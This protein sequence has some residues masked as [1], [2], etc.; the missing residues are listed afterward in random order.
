MK[1]KIVFLMILGGLWSACTGKFQEINTNPNN[2]EVV[3]TTQVL[4][5]VQRAYCGMFGDVWY[6]YNES[7]SMAGQ[8]TKIRYIDEARYVY[9]EGTVNNMFN[10]PYV[11]FLKNLN[12]II[13]YE[14]VDNGN[15]NMVA[16]ARIFKAYIFQVMTDHLG[17]IPYFNAFKVLDK[18]Y[19]PEYDPQKDI[20]ADLIR[21]VQAAVAMI[22]VN[23]PVPMRFGNADFFF[24]GDMNRWKK[25]GNS[26][27]L[28]MAIRLSYVEPNTAKT[29]ISGILANE[30]N[31]MQSNADNC[32][33]R[34]PGSPYAEPLSNAEIAR[35]DYGMANVIIGVL[36]ET[37]DPRL[38]VYAAPAPEPDA[39]NGTY[40]GMPVGLKR[41]WEPRGEFAP[42]SIS[43]VG[44]R[45]R[46]TQ[47]PF[48]GITCLMRYSEIE[49]IKAEAYER[50]LATGD[51]KAAYEKGILASL[52]EN[53]VGGSANAYLSQDKV[54]FDTPQI[55]NLLWASVEQTAA[56]P[57]LNSI[58]NA[59]VAASVKLQKIAYQK[60]LALFTTGPE[61]WA[62]MRRTDIPVIGPA[63]GRIYPELPH[64]RAP[65]RFPYAFAESGNNPENYKKAFAKTKDLYWGEKMYWDVRV[66]VN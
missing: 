24:A 60:W 41:E 1:N 21:E 42:N 5:Y 19:Y 7:S 47:A 45:F 16:A 18:N 50:G 51:A 46:N 61:A 52:E 53:G 22:D 63:I 43:P 33:F 54:A 8:V 59:T 11:N 56:S 2:P 27:L 9:R 31:V 49:F 10:T 48:S 40:K 26:L 37:A 32:I 38:P 62:E 44:A 66:G 57:E 64:N 58:A 25:F 28:R 17:D 4:T 30:A 15:K 14:S 23:P 12:K 35:K 20:Y 13:E 3:P 29:L 6:N 55:P 34:W 36:K 39:V 65:L